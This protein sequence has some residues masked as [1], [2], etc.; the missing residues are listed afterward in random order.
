MTLEHPTR[1]ADRAD[2]VVAPRERSARR[3]VGSGAK[4]VAGAA[5]VNASDGADARGAVVE[6]VNSRYGKSRPEKVAVCPPEGDPSSTPTRSEAQKE[7]GQKEQTAMKS[8]G[9]DLGTRKIVYAV[10]EN[11]QVCARGTV[12]K[13]ADLARILGP[14]TEKARVALE[15]SR[16]AWAVYD[17]VEAWG[18]EVK[19]VD[20]TRVKELGIGAHG[21]KTDRLDAEKLAWGA[22]HDR[23]PEAHVLSKAR[24]ALRT[25]V[26]T[27]RALVELQ[28]QLITTIRGIFRSAGNRIPSCSSDVFA[29]KVNVEALATELRASVVPLLAVLRVTQQ[30]IVTVDTAI[31]AVCAKEP[32]VKLLTTAPGVGLVVAAMFVS[33]IDDATRFSSARAVSSYLGLVPRADNSGMRTQRLG[34][35][36]KA[37]NPYARALLVQ[38]AWSVL[39]SKSEDDP[40]VL[41][42]RQVAERRGNNIAVVAVARRLTGIL[43]AMWRRSTA[44]DPLHIGHLMADGQ[45]ARAAT[46]ASQAAS[47]R[48]GAAKEKLRRT[49]CARRAVLLAGPAKSKS[50]SQG[51]PAMAAP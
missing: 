34:A 10:I 43:W 41:W 4:L 49:I 3:R 7:R 8:V 31:E 28:T 15:A 16:E 51:G 1:P 5:G 20:T 30:Q 23:I 33:V 35:I 19:M 2:P 37:G 18:H 14:G 29:T 24:R 42:A 48:R 50:K 11:G 17:Q 46:I 32:A 9:L 45:E 12:E 13:V 40:V 27:R 25:E 21:R 26:Q 36:S 47:L 39:R 6:P 22:Y 44:Y 38:A